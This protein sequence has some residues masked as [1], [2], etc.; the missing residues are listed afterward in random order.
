MLMT[1]EKREKGRIMMRQK[2]RLPRNLHFTLLFFFFILPKFWS[3]HCAPKASATFS[4]LFCFLNYIL[5]RLPPSNP[6]TYLSPSF[7]YHIKQQ[8]PA[9]TLIIIGPGFWV[10]VYKNDQVR[11]FNDSDTLM[12]SAYVRYAFE[13]YIFLYFDDILLGLHISYIYKYIYEDTQIQNA[14]FI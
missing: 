9:F 1:R 13:E 11:N 14:Y 6:K 12:K 5:I 8:F 7:Q 10:I 3:Q 4:F 2:L